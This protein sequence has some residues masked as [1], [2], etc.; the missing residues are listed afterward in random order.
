MLRS[1]MAKLKIS[2]ILSPV[3]VSASVDLTGIDNAGFGSLMFLVATGAF[4]YDGTNK[5]TIKVQHS[6]TDSAYADVADGDIYNAETP[7]S[8]I[9]KVLDAA[10]DAEAVHAIHYLGEKRF[11][12]LTFTEGG[13]CTGIIG[14]EAIQGHPQQMPPA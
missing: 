2:K 1:L 14:V 12:R 3:A 10:G 5:I 13:T 8:A 7:A 11:V 4:A 9:A 6:D